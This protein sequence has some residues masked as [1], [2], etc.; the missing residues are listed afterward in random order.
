MSNYLAIATV[1]AC[2]YQILQNPV[3]AAVSGANVGFGRPQNS[4]GTTQSGP[5]VNAYLYQVT[6]NAAY[7]NVDLPTRR[8]DGTLVKKTLTALDLH[9]LFTFTGD[10]TKLEPQL[11][12]GVVTSTLNAQPYIS[13]QNITGAVKS[14]P[15]LNGS[16]LDT[17]VERVRFTPSALTLDEFTKLWSSFFQVEYALSAAYQ[18]SVVLIESDDTPQDALPV[19]SRKLYVTPFRRPVID[20]VVA[21][22][23]A[24]QPILPSSTLVIQG[25]NFISDSTTVQIG[26]VP[27]TPPTV[28]DKAIILPVPA[29]ASAGVQGVQVIQQ[30]LM[31]KPPVLH[32]G[33]ES[34]VA[35]IVLHPTITPQ[36]PTAT[37]IVVGISPNVQPNQRV[38]LLLNE[39][40]VP[41]P[42]APAAYSF[43]LPPLTASANQLTFPLSGVQGGGTVYFVRVTVD[44]ADSQLDLNP[45]SPTFGPTVTFS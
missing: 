40:T 30:T 34:N 16:G 33:F 20:Q 1:S 22:A 6:P 29:N 7:R 38:T 10:D 31:G 25:S 27:A 19:Q 2:L 45:A 28:T 37:Q 43:P 44:G 4:T 21:Q 17:Q 14:F 23:G 15:I 36:A 5:M 32:S 3:S 9:Y 11:M 24:N 42:A 12:L 35:G 13:T 26:N 41:P 39:A 8:G 18:A